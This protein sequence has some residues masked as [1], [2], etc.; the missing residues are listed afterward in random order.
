VKLK[1]FQYKIETNIS[2]VTMDKFIKC[3][4]SEE[5]SCLSNR[6][7]TKAKLESA[8]MDIFYAYLEKTDTTTY[9]EIKQL[10]QDICVERAK[11]ES[12]KI[13]VAVLEHKYTQKSADML[14]EYGH[15]FNFSTANENDYIKQLTLVVN[16]N[17]MLLINLNTYHDKLAKIYEDKQSK[18][19]QEQDFGKQFIYLNSILKYGYKITPENTTIAEYCDMLNIYKAK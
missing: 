9:R 10:L 5:Y 17:K 6:P 16:R 12:V 19:V 4:T 18:T 2:V 1:K 7:H 13:C 3:V 8:W 15:T 14:K 11:Y